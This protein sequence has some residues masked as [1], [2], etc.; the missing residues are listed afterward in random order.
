[1]AQTLE[2][3]T[4]K[5][6]RLLEFFTTKELAMQIGHNQDWWPIA[7]TKELLDNALD[8][9]ES[10]GIAPEIKVTLNGNSV[11]I[12]DNGPG[13]PVETLKKSLDYTVRVSDKL[14][15]V[16]PSRGQ[17]GNAL[18]CIWA[19]PFVAGDNEH[20]RVD[21]I[22]GGERH[23]I[24]ISLDRIA[25]AP[26]L[27]MK[28][29]PNGIVK[30]GTFV[31]MYWPQIA[32]YL[33]HKRNGDFYNPPLTL[34]ALVARYAYF[35]P[36]AKFEFVGMDA[37]AVF[38][39]TNQ[40]WEKWQP[41]TP[42]SPHW[43]DTN[44]L[45]NLIGAYI[46]DER[47]GGEPKSTRQFVGEFSGL[48]S[49]R[50]QKEIA[51]SINH[52]Y[53]H[54]LVKNGGVSL[55]AVRSLQAAMRVRSRTVK[56]HA[57]GV[58]GEEHFRRTSDEWGTTDFKYVKK[59][60][61]VDDD[62]PYVLE[63]AFGV[64]PDDC[65]RE[66]IVG[67]NWAPAL[68]ATV[69][70][71][72]LSQALDECMVDGED[73]VVLLIH[74]AYPKLSFKDRGKSTLDLPTN[75]WWDF[76]KAIKKVTRDWTQYK[77]KL[78]REQKAEQKEWVRIQ[79]S[80]KRRTMT[81][82]EA[83]FEVMDEVHSVVSAN[84]RL[85]AKP[86][87]MMYVARP[88]VQKLTGGKVWKNSSYFTQRL[89]PE[90]VKVYNPDWDIV[91]D[92]R[93]RLTEPHTH[94]QVPLGMLEVRNYV[95][96]WETT[97]ELKSQ[98]LDHSI[99]TLG[100]FN[101][102]S[103]A[104]FVEKEGFGPLWRAVKLAERWDLA[105]FSTKGMS[106]VAARQLVDELSLRGVTILVTRDFD[107]AGF[108]IVETLR[109]DGE[110]YKFKSEPKVIDLGLRLEDVDAMGLESEEVV[111][112]QEKDPRINLYQNGATEEECKFLVRRRQGRN[113]WLGE[114]V[115]LN[116]MTSEQL[117]TWLE[118]KLRL[119]GVGK[120]VP[121]KET[122][123]TAYKRATLI[124][125]MQIAVDKVWDDFDGAAIEI[126]EDLEQQVTDKI[127][128]TEQAWDDAVWNICNDE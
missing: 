96:N 9:C 16:S 26:I 67:I 39:A 41:N 107:K 125:E 42:T 124:A 1:M 6:S 61:M 11:S 86:R 82:K 57:L 108:S 102:Y 17:L 88:L 101:R 100:P 60:G 14:H 84:G 123:E 122:L 55:V 56:A 31:K 33:R 106:V 45:L 70:G 80:K 92:A 35:N 64:R 116:A 48:S 23:T 72:V 76:N 68:K 118:S 114:R 127:R 83:T 85:P 112:D 18:K 77:K 44:E 75:I 105:I 30:I 25:Q 20:G 38:D 24:N 117:V 15:Y 65:T 104:L 8:A 28:T 121:I 59:T 36:H 109:T 40:E 74:L 50:K 69:F 79:E 7:L 93:G 99:S 120:V 5:T 13:L 46:S 52:E 58:I 115:E 2:R 73:P 66:I 34:S 32:G 51:E 27:E 91:Y 94:Q 111:Y 81:I 12:Q 103:F 19:A 128:G 78:R 21:V 49:T 90:Y 37:E 62:I 54:D 63:V 119:H 4:F 3:T 10:D 98:E 87:Q 47:N 89:L 97:L 71:S 113:R 95:A 22:T 53:L 110:R 29:S 126:P 43:Y